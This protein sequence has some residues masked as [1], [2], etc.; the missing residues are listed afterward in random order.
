[1]RFGI[2]GALGLPVRLHAKAPDNYRY[3][4]QAQHGKQPNP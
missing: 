1:M 4:G 2:L 3:R